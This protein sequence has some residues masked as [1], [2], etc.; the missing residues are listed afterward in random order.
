MITLLF[1]IKKL[2]FMIIFILYKYLSSEPFCE[3]SIVVTFKEN[4]DWSTTGIS[5]TENILILI[6]NISFL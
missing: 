5:S 1:G 2:L 6:K 4:A 3:D